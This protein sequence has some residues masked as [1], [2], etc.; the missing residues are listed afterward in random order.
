MLGRL[1]LLGAI[2]IGIVTGA[3]FYRFVPKAKTPKLL[4]T[5]EFP[6]RSDLE[7]A[8]GLPSGS[9]DD[10]NQTIFGMHIK[11]A[12]NTPE[13]ILNALYAHGFYD[14]KYPVEIHDSVDIDDDKGTQV[15]QKR[16]EMLSFL[17][18]EDITKYFVEYSLDGSTK[19]G[20]KKNISIESRQVRNIISELATNNLK[21]SYDER[22]NLGPA[23]YINNLPMKFNK[24]IKQKNINIQKT[25]EDIH[26]I[27]KLPIG[28]TKIVGDYCFFRAINPK[29]ISAATDTSVATMTKKC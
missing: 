20:L 3:I 2:A 4:E 14:A 6:S 5:S 26:V 12:N 23:F 22:F 13:S 25:L 29:D 9:I 21:C 24:F 10:A 11:T 7:S 8:L 27:S 15:N 17:E 19:I 16:V 18:D 1:N 28:V